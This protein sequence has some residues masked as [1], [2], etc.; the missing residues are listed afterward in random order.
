MHAPG[1]EMKQQNLPYKVR[2]TAEVDE[3]F[4]DRI[5]DL[6]R[7]KDQIPIVRYFLKINASDQRKRGRVQKI[8]MVMV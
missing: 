1:L 8:L 2:D 5:A 7:P 4:R 3:Y 6:N